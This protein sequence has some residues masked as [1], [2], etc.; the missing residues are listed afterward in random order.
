[1]FLRYYIQCIFISE[2][3]IIDSSI[4]LHNLFF[5]CNVYILRR[6]M[7]FAAFDVINDGDDD[8]DDDPI[9]HYLL[10]VSSVVVVVYY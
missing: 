4:L 1:M 6:L 2:C 5:N 10:K 7:Y 3:F 8:D 9:P